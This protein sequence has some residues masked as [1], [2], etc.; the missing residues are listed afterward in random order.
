MSFERAPPEDSSA[1]SG[2]GAEGMRTLLRAHDWSATPLGAMTGWP[3][4]LKT[5]VELI[6]PNRFPSVILWGRDLIQI[7]ND[8]FRP[9]MA[10][11]HP[12]GLGQPARECWPEVWHIAG[13]IYERVRQGESLMFED[14]LY[15]VLRNGALKD[16][17]YDV[18]YSP[19]ADETGSIGGVLVTVVEVT[20]QHLAR[21]GQERRDRLIGRLATIVESSD[22]A[23][24][25][26]DLDGVI[27]T[28]N[29]GA[30]RIFGYTA[31][32]AIGK[33]ITIL[34][35]PDRVDE[36]PG[37]LARIR[38]GERIDH[39]ETVRRRKDGS[40]ADISLTISP[41]VDGSGKV[42]AAS[43]IARDIGPRKRA[44]AALREAEERRA[45]LLKLADAIRPL[46][47]A[48]AIQHAACAI[49]RAQLAADRICYCETSEQEKSILITAEDAASGD[50]LVGQCFRLVHFQHSASAMFRDLRPVG[51]SDVKTLAELSPEQ[52]AAF[53][54]LGIGA[55]LAVPIAKE[56]RLV[57]ALIA[58]FSTP[59]PWSAR[60]L[61]LLGETAERTWDAA[62]RA[63]TEAA[64]RESEAQLQR[65]SRAKDEFIAMLGHE[66]RN[67]LA[68]IATTLELMKLR[69][70][71]V[72]VREREI[73]DAQVR[74]LTGLVD[75]LLDVARI[76]SGKVELKTDE[77]DV[78]EMVAAAVEITQP[79]ME[80]HQQS[81]RTRVE[82][83]LVVPGDKR[84]L[85]QIAVNL[86]TNAAKYSP[87]GRR[88]DVRAIRE[89][90]QVVLR[91]SD[92]GQ[93]IDP[94]LLPHVFEL[95]T[96]DAQ[97]AD[98]QMGG[99]GLGLAIVR[100][101][102]TLHGG[103]VEATSEGRGKGSEFTVRLP[104]MRRQRKGGAVKTAATASVDPEDHRAKVKVLIVDDYAL[105]AES[106]AL[107]LEEMGY[108]TRV[109]HDGPSGLQA[110]AEFE[111]D[112]ALVD[113][114]LPVMDGYE[115]AHTVRRTPGC[116][117]MPL[118]AITGFGQASDH[119]RAR[120]AGFDEHLVKPLEAGKIGELI[121]ALVE[122]RA[123][124]ESRKKRLKPA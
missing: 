45:F 98:R 113:I 114:G 15:P 104:L 52:K 115:V 19:I 82:E 111:P 93:G 65:A 121:D 58:K 54:A 79:L 118:V 40:L 7:Y 123:R 9:L 67:P 61:Q 39:Y 46:V 92:E 73:I 108:V 20:A 53:A 14:A 74:H 35:P 122:A 72:F 119:A 31:E 86:L 51:C 48:R 27:Q 44:D 102:V 5:A 29:A 110:I 2:S 120:A 12:A 75:D 3:Q 96:Q 59:H 106:L 101:L 77:V 99:L 11:K 41:I 84:R 70:P 23:I 103:S 42:V 80:E 81:L 50:A 112:I 95:F 26:K 56:G 55:Y 6:L 91:V 22:D 64:L 37:I 85:V 90:R 10:D 25:S 63:S 60:E 117:R 105:A 16:A 43:K 13:P 1:A 124:G 57:A 116:E 8:S 88:I 94:A 4:T 107:L 87:P 89:N 100:N 76:A 34:M 83:G 62:Q 109:A 36:E 97:S 33:P 21:L 47:D 49:L 17:W 68:P 24:I 32:D 30:E 78:E 28:W 71:D 38:R 69:S 66:L 18:C